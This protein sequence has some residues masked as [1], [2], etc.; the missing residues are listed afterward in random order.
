VPPPSPAL[1]RPHSQ[2]RRLSALQRPAERRMRLALPH[3]MAARRPSLPPTLK[4]TCTCSGG[5]G[6]DNDECMLSCPV[7][8]PWL[9]RSPKAWRPRSPSQKMVKTL[10]DTQRPTKK[11]WLCSKKRTAA[12]VTAGCR[13]SPLK[14]SPC[15]SH[16]TAGRPG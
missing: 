11:N 6:N 2:A 1:P 10:N 12:A 7:F 15:I 4:K 9:A 3:T 8:C 14:P 13:P 16:D 5:H